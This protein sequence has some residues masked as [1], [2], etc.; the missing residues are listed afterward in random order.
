[1]FTAVICPELSPPP[2]GKVI[3]AN[4]SYSAEAII[5]CNEGYTHSKSRNIS[6]TCQGNNTWSGG[7]VVCKRMF[8]VF[9]KN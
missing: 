5:Q 8:K 9:M 1:M 4:R 7:V 3:Y 2:D 6:V